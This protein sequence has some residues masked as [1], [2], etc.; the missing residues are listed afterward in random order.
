MSYNIC[1]ILYIIYYILYIM[2]YILCIIYYVLYI[3]VNGLGF[4]ECR[5][6]DNVLNLANVKSQ[7]KLQRRSSVFHRLSGLVLAA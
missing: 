2:Y 3:I 7:L 4:V 6:L 1:Y 5:V